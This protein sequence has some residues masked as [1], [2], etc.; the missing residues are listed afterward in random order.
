MPRVTVVI[1]HY[2]DLGGLELCLASL[3]RQTMPRDQ[4]EIVVADN[5]SPVGLRAIE[6]VIA[7]RARLTVCTEKG[8]GPNRN[9]GVEIARGEILAFI[10][11]DCQ[12]EPQWLEN[13]LRGLAA[14]DFIGGQVKVLVE[15]PANLTPA[16]AFE[17]VFAFDFETYINK[18]GFTGAGNMICS[19]E[20]FDAVGGFR[21]GVSEDVEWSQ[22]AT[23]AGFRLGYVPDAVVG[24]PA[25]RS[26]EELR[27][28]WLRVNTETFK[29]HNK[30]RQG[31]LRWLA[32]CAALPVS[33]VV[34]TP[35][36]IAAPQLRSWR[37][38]LRALSML[39]RL[40]V[41]RAG[42]SLSLIRSGATG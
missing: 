30:R 28:K 23:A 33:A 7:G 35:K 34:H 39:Y 24:H 36:V 13:G 5:A 12:A 42:H 10:D 20:V 18:K 17:A 3:D 14:Y 31:R 37:D 27:G 26:W 8:A 2:Q 6:D 16:E 38:R 25:R 4:F 41:W 11:S 40:R 21:N 19:R 22:R 9:A 15:D 29:L 1:P 32:R